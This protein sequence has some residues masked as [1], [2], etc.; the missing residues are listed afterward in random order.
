MLQD[1]A[2]DFM[3]EEITDNDDYADWIQWVADAEQRKQKPSEARNV[4]QES[5]LL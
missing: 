3:K 1:K 4:G 2:T 5:V